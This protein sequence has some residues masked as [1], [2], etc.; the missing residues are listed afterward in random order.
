MTEL[1]RHYDRGGILLYVGIS[2]CTI[3]RLAAHK[4]ESSWYKRIA[5]VTIEHFDTRQDALR[6]E[7]HAIKTEKPKYNRH[8]AIE[9]IKP[10]CGYL[11]KVAERVG[12]PRTTLLKMKA[13]GEFDLQPVQGTRLYRFDEVD[14]WAASRGSIL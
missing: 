13:R 8:H 12:I 3:I 10:T 11:T 1:Y 4:F 2:A 6:A 5:I 7:T 14:V 9:T